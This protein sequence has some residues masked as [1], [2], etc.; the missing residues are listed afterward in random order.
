MF[1]KRRRQRFVSHSSVKSKKN[2]LM[3]RIWIIAVW[4]CIW[5]SVCVLT[6]LE[7]I[8]ASPVNVFIALWELV[9][10]SVFYTVLI[11]SFFHITIGFLAAC[12]IA[13]VLGV[14]AGK[15]RMVHEFFMPLIHMM[16]SLPI[17]SFII[18]LLILFGSSKSV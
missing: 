4:L 6:G 16:K 13:V 10:T 12:I 7:L 15:Y 5:Q 3:V 14:L 11:N 8:L 1:I 9:R 17:A 18:L 2:L